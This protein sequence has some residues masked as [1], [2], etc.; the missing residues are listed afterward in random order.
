MTGHDSVQKYAMA[1]VMVFSF[2]VSLSAS[3]QAIL[4]KWLAK[5]H[6]EAME[7]I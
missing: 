6:V 1:M 4:I 7:G 5:R 3:F 2:L